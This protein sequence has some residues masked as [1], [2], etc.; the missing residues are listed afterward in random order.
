MDAAKEEDV[1]PGSFVRFDSENFD[2][3]INI[4]IGIRRRLS[5]LV[6]IPGKI[7]DKYEYK[8]RLG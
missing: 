5:C 4:L 7:L 6:E 3:I 1:G 8:K 2:I